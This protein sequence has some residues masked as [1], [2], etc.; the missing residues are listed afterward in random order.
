MLDSKTDWGTG[1]PGQKE[2]MNSISISQYLFSLETDRDRH[3]DIETLYF[4]IPPNKANISTPNLM[5][6]FCSNYLVVKQ[7]ILHSLSLREMGSTEK[8]KINKHI[9]EGKPLWELL[10]ATSFRLS[11]HI[12]TPILLWQVLSD[13]Q[14]VCIGQ[15]IFFLYYHNICERLL[16]E[17]VAK[18]GAAIALICIHSNCD[19]FLDKKCNFQSGIYCY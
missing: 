15:K 10:V 9:T 2:K 7:N 16:T 6:N 14:N 12:P 8:R 19:F 1:P 5:K 4:E 13:E 18:L 3:T 11:S 17:V